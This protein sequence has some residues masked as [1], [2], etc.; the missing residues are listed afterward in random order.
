MQGYLET[1]VLAS[2][3]DGT[4]LRAVTWVGLCVSILYIISPL[5]NSWCSMDRVCIRPSLF[6]PV[7]VYPYSPAQLLIVPSFTL[8]CPQFGQFITWTGCQ[9]ICVHGLMGRTWKDDTHA[10]S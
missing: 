1:T 2:G 4:Q 3:D 5:L 6:K 10:T 8:Q 9:W 7:Q